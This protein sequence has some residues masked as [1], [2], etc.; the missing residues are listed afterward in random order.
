[1]ATLKHL[2][3]QSFDIEINNAE[4]P[5]LVDFYADWCGPCKALAPVLE[6]VA[7]ASPD[8][9]SVVKVDIDDSPELAVRYGIQK[10]PTLVLFS[11]GEVQ[12]RITGLLSRADLLGRIEP[13][14]GAGQPAVH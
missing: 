5:V 2:D 3:T 8:S 12:A 4:T 11:G 7:E 13:F 6:S 1:M 9:L 10:I 14:I